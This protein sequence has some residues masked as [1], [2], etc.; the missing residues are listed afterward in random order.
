VVRRGKVRFVYASR[1]RERTERTV[2]P[3]GLV[4]KDDIWYLVAGTER[5]QRTFR[6]D[7]IGELAVTE[8][9]FERPAGFVLDEAWTQLVGTIE[10]NRSRTWA[11]VL[12]P[13]RFLWVLQD[14]FGRHCHP[15]PT[16][17]DGRVQ[18]RVGAPTARDIARTLSGWG[19]AVEVIE[20]PEVRAELTRIGS[21]LV[22]LYSADD[23]DGE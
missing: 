9:T 14:H 23:E 19:S 22:A 12:I 21:E 3:W 13:E 7:R 18:A 8:R 20:S 1:G 5:G 4:D 11:T 16:L 15:G 6:V 10:E 17:H 2:D